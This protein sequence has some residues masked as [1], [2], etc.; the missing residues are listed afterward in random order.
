[1]TVRV[2]K[3][4]FNLRDK[5][6]KLELPVG[7]HGSQILKSE[8]PQDTFNIISAGRK[9]MII[10]GDMRVSQRYSSAQT[11]SSG[12]N[13]YFLDRWIG[14]NDTGA[15]VAQSH[16]AESP[17][18]HYRSLRLECSGADTSMG[19]TEYCRI[20]QY[21]E[22]Y[23][24]LLDWGMGA[25][26]DFA[27]ISFW[28]QSSVPGIYS[29]SIEDGDASTFCMNEYQIN[30]PNVWEWKTVTVPPPLNGDFVA[31]GTNTGMRVTFTLSTA[32]QFKTT[33]D[34]LGRW[35]SSGDYDMAGPN[36]VNFVGQTGNFY[37]TGV[38]LERGKVATPF[39]YMRYPEQLALCQRY[40][41][42]NFPEGVP[43]Q[44]AYYT[45]TSNL[46]AGFNG[47]VCFSSSNA[48]SPWVMFNQKMNHQPDVTLYSASTSD[49]AG[50]WA[51]YTSGG[52]W[53]SGS[54]NSIDYFGNQGFGVRY[55]SGGH[56]FNI[57]EAYLY[58]GMWAADAEL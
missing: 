55:G 6:S 49:T 14:R 10:N 28:V 12:G 57:G 48:R 20:Q 8:T 51:A 42:S 40:F 54:S 37:L 35:D 52:G 45:T 25:N 38:Q 18:G 43:P 29:V 1:M 15:T 3:A 39:E 24:I 53:N 9:N 46:A 32:T 11:I 5:L 47:V 22:G 33:A 58:R 17:D 41:Q 16:S 19:G 30:R 4:A 7:V 36:Q 34:Q 44:N 13:R 26:R 2:E 21:I 23:N 50:K 31:K 56:S 27:T